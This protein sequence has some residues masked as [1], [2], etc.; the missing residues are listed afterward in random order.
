MG[1][2]SA[3]QREVER[4]AAHR[5]LRVKVLEEFRESYPARLLRLMHFHLVRHNFIGAADSTFTIN[6]FGAEDSVELPAVDAFLSATA[7]RETMQPEADAQY[8]RVQEWISDLELMEHDMDST[9]QSEQRAFQE[10]VRKAALKEK[11]LS[12]MKEAGVS[13]DELKEVMGMV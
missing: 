7:V 1:R 3:V 11:V 6:G 12:A 4:Q 13:R 9:L 8:R 2:M 10:R 5:A